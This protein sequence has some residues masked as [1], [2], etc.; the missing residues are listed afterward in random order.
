MPLLIVHRVLAQDKDRWPLTA[1][2]RQH[3][4]THLQ[5]NRR[6]DRRVCWPSARREALTS[7]CLCSNR[8]VTVW[9]KKGKAFT[10][11]GGATSKDRL[12]ERRVHVVISQLRGSREG[13]AW[14]DSPCCT[15]C[16]RRRTISEMIITYTKVTNGCFFWGGGRRG[17]PIRRYSTIILFYH[18]VEE[19]GR[20]G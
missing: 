1:I 20:Y 4:S 6:G 17:R 18:Y 7:A 8:G 19:D 14:Q 13:R 12:R 10:T 2:I 15:K 11:R 3:R 16:S 5:R 9:T